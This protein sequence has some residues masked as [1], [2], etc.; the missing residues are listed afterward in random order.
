MIPRQKVL[1]TA[2]AQGE[3]FD[4]AELEAWLDARQAE[5]AT[6]RLPIESRILLGRW[7]QLVTELEGLLHQRHALSVAQNSQEDNAQASLR[8]QAEI[9][10]TRALLDELARKI[11][12][13]DSSSPQC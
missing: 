9:G 13:F 3:P 1:A 4:L 8:K 10:K 6:A 5:V 7:Q 11:R 12:H 2:P